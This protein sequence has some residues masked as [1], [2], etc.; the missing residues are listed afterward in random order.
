M[1]ECRDLQKSSTVTVVAQRCDALSAGRETRGDNGRRR[2]RTQ[3]PAVRTARWG[4]VV[5][6]SA[7]VTDRR[8]DDVKRLT[9][10][11]GI[12]SFAEFNSD[13][14]AAE[15]LQEAETEVGFGV[16]VVIGAKGAVRAPGSSYRTT[17]PVIDVGL[18]A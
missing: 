17:H 2:L 15:A 7:T 11:W 8:I 13:Q 18:T 10:G 12:E 9:R 16:R 5:R 14:T 3:Q 4:R 6:H 1:E